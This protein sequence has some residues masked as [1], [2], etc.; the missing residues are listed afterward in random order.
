MASKGL[1]SA[2][3]AKI[4]CVFFSQLKSRGEKGEKNKI[5]WIS[6]LSGQAGLGG[7]NP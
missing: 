5:N 3:P 4:Y 6:A 1:V 7:G 2:F